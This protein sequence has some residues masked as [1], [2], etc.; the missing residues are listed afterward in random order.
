[1]NR[2]YLRDTNPLRAIN[3]FAPLPPDSRPKR[4]GIWRCSVPQQNLQKAVKSILDGNGRLDR[5]ACS[6]PVLD[7]EELPD[8][9]EAAEFSNRII[10]G[11]SVLHAPSILAAEARSSTRM[12]RL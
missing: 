1:M 10:C 3:H 8:P 4:P 6:T 5:L 12:A 7:R 9:A 2:P 11:Q